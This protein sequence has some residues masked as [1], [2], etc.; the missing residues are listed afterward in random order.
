[1]LFVENLSY[2]IKKQTLVRNLNLSV[3]PGEFIA[4]LGANGAGKSTLIKLL[5]GEYQPVEGM[6]KLHGHILNEYKDQQ[7][8]VIRATMSQ[9]HQVSAD[10]TV[11]EVV[12]MGRY[13]HFNGNPKTSDLLIIEKAMNICGIELLAERSILSLSGGERQ[14]VHLAR[15]LVQVWE[16]PQALLLLDEPISA[17]DI[18]FQH[19]ALSIA[20]ALAD[21]GWMVI[22]VLHDINLSA[23]YADRL[24]LMKNG[25]KLMDGTAAEVITS[26]NMY[27]VFGI[28]ADISVNPKTLRTHIIPKQIKIDREVFK[29]GNSE[30]EISFSVV[31]KPISI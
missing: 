4:V 15:I 16:H 3:R 14:R 1:M 10:F 28:D 19:Q 17:M 29:L 18:R 31:T 21:K 30:E 6:I 9:E 2:S 12:T 24:I 26:R 13:P 11:K 27:T 20:R 22:S 25:R 5:S 23:Q 8:A 7:L